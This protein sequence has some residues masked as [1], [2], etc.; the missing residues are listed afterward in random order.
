MKFR[1]ILII[2]ILILVATTTSGCVYLEP[3][4]NVDVTITTNGSDVQLETSKTFL[5]FDTVPTS[6]KRE[7][8]NKALADVYNDTS[9]LESIKNDMQEIAE[10]YDYNVTVTIDSQY[11]KDQL[12]MVA[13][14]KGTSM[15][16]TLQDGQDVVLLKSKN[17]KVGDIVV[18]SHPEHGLIVK[19]V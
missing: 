14:V 18:A 13:T 10:Y 12:P 2:T 9:T 16:P 4:Q 8:T 3:S 5:F 15:L 11:G 7:M 17:V 1:D 6:M 19:R